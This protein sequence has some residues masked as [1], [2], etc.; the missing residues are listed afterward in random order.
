MLNALDGD[1]G[2]HHLSLLPLAQAIGLSSI[3]QSACINRAF[4]IF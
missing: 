1:D 3:N 2:L 4:E